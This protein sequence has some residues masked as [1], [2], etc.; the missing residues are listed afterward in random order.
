MLPCSC[1]IAYN[2][3]CLVP[4]VGF[5][6]SHIGFVQLDHYANWNE[7]LMAKILMGN[8]GNKVWI[9]IYDLVGVRNKG[10]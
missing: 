1:N 7:C 2:Y 8:Q 5:K 10:K 4:K 3:L 9:H 6:M